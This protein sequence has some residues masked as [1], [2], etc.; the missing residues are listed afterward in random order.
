MHLKS[1]TNKL[2]PKYFIT[3][4]V[5]AK[6][7]TLTTFGA[8]HCL[9]EGKCSQKSPICPKC[10]PDVSPEVTPSP[11]LNLLVDFRF[12]NHPAHPPE[13]DLLMD[14]KVITSNNS[15]PKLDLLMEFRFDQITSPPPGLDLL[16]K[17]FNIV[18]LSAFER[19]PSHCTSTIHSPEPDT[20]ACNLCGGSNCLSAGYWTW[21]PTTICRTNPL[22]LFTWQTGSHSP[23][24]NSL[25]SSLSLEIKYL[26]PYLVLSFFVSAQCQKLAR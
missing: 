12:W 8:K 21:I 6:Q 18:V 23:Y 4:L 14:F 22:I 25:R 7:T 26:F 2:D 19:L 13:M 3:I 17:N 10:S 16:M 1:D 24:L 11:E 5:F 15:P 9:S 20:M